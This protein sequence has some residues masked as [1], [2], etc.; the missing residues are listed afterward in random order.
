MARSFPLAALVLLASCSATVDPG[1]DY[2]QAARGIRAATGADEVFDP[3][4]SPTSPEEVRAALA[5][6]LT[7]E[8][9]LRIALR[10]NRRLQAAFFELG[11]ARAEVVQSGLLRNPSLALAVFLP[12]GGGRTRWTADLLADVLDLWEI[13]ARRRA[14]SRVLEQRTLELVRLATEL[15]FRT[16]ET[17]H[18][19]V[20]ARARVELAGQD[21]E[22]AERL[23]DAVARQVQEGVATRTEAALADG[24]ALSARLS[25][26]SARREE[27]Q[28]RRDLATL[29]SL[30]DD[31]DGVPLSEALPARPLPA[32]DPSRL[33]AIGLARRADLA[34]AAEAVAAAEANVALERRRRAPEVSA[35]LSA[36]RPEGAGSSGL[37][38]GPTATVELPVLDRNQAQISRAELELAARRREHAA[39]EVEVTQEIQAAIDQLD[40]ADRAERLATEELV[41]RAEQAS[42]L[43]ERSHALGDTLVLEVL[44]ARRAVIEARRAAVESRLEAARA[45]ADLERTIGAP[46]GTTAP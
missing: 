31:L 43:A 29:L 27:R 11:V 35:G 19:A 3:E 18:R 10:D 20:A 24:R 40:E 22:L 37:L 4:G 25:A 36:E 17:Y 13:P 7:L 38:L 39:L 46:L 21:V 1:P 30:E 33:V 2:A 15:A 16:R 45:L 5:D 14:A 34:A 23:R 9:A 41:P 44:H 28:V 8:E 6:G 12:D 26:A 42:E 32:L